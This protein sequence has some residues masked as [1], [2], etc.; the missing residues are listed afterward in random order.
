MKKGRPGNVLEVLVPGDRLDPISELVFRETTT[1]GVRY[2]PVYRKVLERE[3][4][5]AQTPWGPVRIKRGLLDGQLV[6]VA[7][8]FEDCRKLAESAGVPVKEVWQEALAAARRGA[9]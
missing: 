9:L 2:Y 3:T 6:N 1:L 5:E 4:V 8:E 7:P